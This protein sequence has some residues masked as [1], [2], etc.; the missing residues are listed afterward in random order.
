MMELG[1]TLVHLERYSEAEDLLLGA[2]DGFRAVFRDQ[3]SHQRIRSIL[4]R[5]IRLYEAWQ[6]K[7][8]VDQYKTLL[9]K[10]NET[11]PKPTSSSQ[12]LARETGP[13]QARGPV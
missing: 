11:R 4:G 12:A 6:R 13:P 1:T 3:P 7:D 2:L 10:A 5:I 9:E 8:K